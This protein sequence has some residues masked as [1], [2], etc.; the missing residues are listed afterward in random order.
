MDVPYSDVYCHL[1]SS[2]GLIYLSF[3]V[4]KELETHPV[5]GFIATSFTG[6]TGH[7]YKETNF[8]TI[9][10]K[11]LLFLTKLNTK[12]DRKNVVC[13]ML[14]F[15]IHGQYSNFI[16]FPIYLSYKTLLKLNP[17]SRM[18]AF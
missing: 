16:V 11:V 14:L 13:Y 10:C 1:S 17:G 8:Q 4:I 6:T 7:E 15:H 2:G 9:N 18:L 5:I 12:R 3:K